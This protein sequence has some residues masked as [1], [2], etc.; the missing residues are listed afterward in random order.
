MQSV[1][2]L[3]QEGWQDEAVLLEMEAGAVQVEVLRYSPDLQPATHVN[4]SPWV[5]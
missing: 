2:A 3:V 5:R 4:D 1:S